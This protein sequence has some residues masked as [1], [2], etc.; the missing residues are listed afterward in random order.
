MYRACPPGP[1]AGVARGFNLLELMIALSIGAMLLG[2]AAPAF[3]EMRL[4]SR[5]AVAVNAFVHSI[6][7]ARST[8]LTHHRT[9][10]ICR[11]V[12][13]ATCSTDTTNWQLGWIVFVNEDRDEPPIRDTNE[14]LLSVQ[15][16]LPGGTITSNRRGYS[17]T[18]HTLSVVNG[19]LVF[20]DRRG[21][22]EARAII[23][24]FAGRP[25]VSQ[26]DSDNRPL[27]CPNG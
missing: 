1:R 21:S 6:F 24:N 3:R 5:R 25:R 2:L 4:D 26:R 17:F 11:S 19:T 12:D 18:W 8:A 13:G 7:L 23:I 9:V 15:E 16:A 14:R 10:S 20:C 22:T 27:R